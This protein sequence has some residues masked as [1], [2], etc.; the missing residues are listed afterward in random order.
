[1]WILFL[2][3][4]IL[5]GGL[6]E[7]FLNARL[8]DLAAHQLSTIILSTIIFIITAVFIRYKKISATGTLLLI[9]AFWSCLTVS[10]E[11]LFFHYVS[12]KPWDVLMADYNIFEGRLF[13]LVIL[14]T[15]FSPLLAHRLFIIKKST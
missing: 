12:G 5:N 3:M 13:S 7:S 15:I 4:A 9:G 14:T 11:F 1:M 10:F 2:A 6:R 8:S